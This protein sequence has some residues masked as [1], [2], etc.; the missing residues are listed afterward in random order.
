MSHEEFES[1][2]RLRLG[3]LPD[4]RRDANFRS[5]VW[6]GLLLSA[7]VL[8]ACSSSQPTSTSTNPYQLVTAKYADCQQQGDAMAHY[9][10]TGLPALY[11]SFGW[12]DQR[13]AALSLV[14]EPRKLYIRQQADVVIL[15][16]DTNEAQQQA[17][18]PTAQQEAQAALEATEQ[19]TCESV[20][21]TWRWGVCYIGYASP[22]DGETYYYSLS[23]D[24]DGKIVPGAGPQDATECASYGEN[25]QTQWHPDT[26]VCSL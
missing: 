15:Q 9:I 8:G 26:D 6:G 22:N 7:V 2:A 19:T 10:D 5:L 24:T 4:A 18:E 23:F 20:E 12:T 25:I 14:G 21:A 17:V 16:C 3:R 13:Q 11:D 1:R